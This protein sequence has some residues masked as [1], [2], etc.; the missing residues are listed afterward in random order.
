VVVQFWVCGGS[1]LGMWW[2]SSVYVVVQFWACGVCVRGGSVLGRWWFS[3]GL[4]V[5]QF[6]NV[7][8]QLVTR[9]TECKI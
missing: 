6:T 7:V 8:A 5:V 4:V 9:L 3:S 2:L 1:V